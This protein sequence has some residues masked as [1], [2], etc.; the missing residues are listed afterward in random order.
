MRPSETRLDD[1]WWTLTMNESINME[2][3]IKLTNNM[4]NQL[5]RN[6]MKTSSNYFKTGLI[7]LLLTLATTLAFAQVTPSPNIPVAANADL[8]T[9]MLNDLGTAVLNADAV[10]FFNPS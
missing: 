2:Y 8:K 7:G 9:G 10:L 3:G 1:P 6:P 4:N 5:H